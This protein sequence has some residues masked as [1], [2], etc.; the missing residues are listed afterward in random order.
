MVA[1]VSG[2]S[3]YAAPLQA[4]CTP[5]RPT[6]Q[7][8]NASLNAAQMN[9]LFASRAAGQPAPVKNVVTPETWAVE[10]AHRSAN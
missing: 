8:S 9:L 6:K 10:V 2:R 7:K 1:S 3:T 5:E 4:Y